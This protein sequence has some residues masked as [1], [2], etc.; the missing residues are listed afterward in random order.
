MGIDNKI[1]LLDNE[2]FILDSLRKILVTLS[3]KYE[4]IYYFIH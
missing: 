1:K 3:E 4:N 2:F